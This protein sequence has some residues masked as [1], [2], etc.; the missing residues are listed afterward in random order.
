ML[1]MENSI[2]FGFCFIMFRVQH[3]LLILEQL[4]ESYVVHFGKR[5]TNLV[6]Y[7]V[8]SI[9]IQLKQGRNLENGTSTQTNDGNYIN[10]ELT[11]QPNPIGGA[12]HTRSVQW[13]QAKDHMSQSTYWTN[14]TTNW[15]L[16]ID[17]PTEDTWYNGKATL[18]R[19]TSP[20]QWA[21]GFRVTVAWKRSEQA[22]W[23]FWAGVKWSKASSNVECRY[24][25]TAA[26]YWQGYRRDWP[27]LAL[28]NFPWWPGP[29]R[30]NYCFELCL[31]LVQCKRCQFFSLLGS[32]YFLF[33]SLGRLNRTQC[34]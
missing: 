25:W 9:I 18:I 15:K 13:L 29:D 16:C 23:Y 26:H 2:T 3:C 31:A 5:Q 34:V 33:I 24:Q 14:W 1:G 32:R 20:S 4:M 10:T 19:W 7:W 22:H 28:F 11:W 8:I 21:I 6:S 27:K 30:K 12:T 17:A